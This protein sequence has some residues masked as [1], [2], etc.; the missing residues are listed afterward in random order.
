MTRKI[1]QKRFPFSAS[2]LAITYEAMKS[3]SPEPNS[4]RPSKNVK[5]DE[6][7]APSPLSAIWEK[8][9]G[10]DAERGGE[11]DRLLWGVEDSCIALLSC[12]ILSR[13]YWSTTLPN[14]TSGMPWNGSGDRGI[15]APIQKRKERERER[16]GG[17]ETERMVL[18]LKL[19]GSIWKLIKRER[20]WNPLYTVPAK[21]EEKKEQYQTDPEA[22][23]EHRPRDLPLDG[24][25]I[26]D[27]E[28][29]RWCCPGPSSS[30][31]TS[32]LSLRASL[33][34]IEGIVVEAI[35]LISSKP[36]TTWTAAAVLPQSSTWLYLQRKWTLSFR[37]E[38]RT[39]LPTGRPD[40]RRKREKW[41]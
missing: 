32:F 30:S 4:G 14:E 34:G 12:V 39:L 38:E 36:W 18:K 20:S 3:I 10:G 11:G 23:A 27:G 22:R 13:R 21:R 40:C 8:S 7:E 28:A 31:S 24:R 15:G 25:W 9:A 19:N 16:K 26:R 35:C 2:F 6:G 1:A 37:K 41:P 33:S 29:V 5:G 17:E